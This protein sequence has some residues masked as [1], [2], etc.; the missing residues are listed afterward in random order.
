[1]KDYHFC[2]RLFFLSMVCLITFSLCGTAMAQKFNGTW[3]GTFS[4]SESGSGPISVTLIQTGSALSGSMSI[5]IGGDCPGTYTFP[6]AG[7]VPDATAIFSTSGTVCGASVTADFVSTS[8]GNTMSGFYFDYV[9][10]QPWDA[11]AFTVNGGTG[12]TGDFSG[13]W[14]GNWSSYNGPYGGSEIASI[15]QTG[16]V[17]SGSM[18]IYNVGPCQGTYAATLT[19]L[20][21]GFSAIFSGSA[22]VCGEP[23]SVQFIGTV[24]GNMLQGTWLDYGSEIY[25][26]GTF[27]VS[28]NCTPPTFP[29]TFAVS[30]FFDPAAAPLNP[31]FI[32]SHV[33]DANLY[34]AWICRDSACS[35][36]SS[37]ALSR[38]SRIARWQVASGLNPNTAYWFKVRS[39]DFCGIGPWS[40]ATPFTTSS[41]GYSL[42]P[43]A[44]AYSPQRDM[45]RLRSHLPQCSCTWTATSNDP[46]IH[47]TSGSSGTGNGT[48][49]YSVDVNT[50]GI[51][52]KGT[53]TIGGQGFTV[54]Q[55]GSTF[56]DDP[57]NMFTPHIYGITTE[58]ITRGCWGDTNYFCPNDVV[59]RGA[60]A[61]FI[62]RAIYGEDFSYT[63]TPYFA[64]VP[65]SN[66]YFKYVQK[67]RDVGITAV[68]GT[69]MVND[70][71]TR[72]AMAA[73]IIRA[74]YGEDF[75]YTQT[76]YFY[77]VP[78][79]N[80][81]FK[82]VQKMKDDGIT[83]NVG[84]YNWTDVV[85]R[86][87]M[88]A[89][90]AR[91]FLGMQ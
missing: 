48:V 33:A 41:C 73:F 23:S 1:M 19:G 76:P 24:S 83:G 71:V 7:S 4:S 34:N 60:M 30:T 75:S 36:I 35:S 58:G 8:S 87:H 64:D 12:L 25:D 21:S 3:T 17:L 9:N 56:I 28:S 63:Q 31:K 54:Y 68:V 40:G 90:L 14:T 20:I 50:T 45:E 29:I 79:S 10:G 44:Y 74:K 22:S 59:T 91:G 27:S 82:Y 86:Q 51:A 78:E 80:G 26:S 55:V 69:Y 88:A 18:T 57:N 84:A 6:I 85:I 61:A 66:G 70:V 67:M 32:W 89:F 77:D 65:P 15:T 53:I 37:A 62:I 46:W 52:R 13:N 49:S 2:K 81:Y 5:T 38:Q 72:G 42:L 16:P 11:G 43:Q 39:V 47:V